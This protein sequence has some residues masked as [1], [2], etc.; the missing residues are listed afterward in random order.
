MTHITLTTPTLPDQSDLINKARDSALSVLQAQNVHR[1]SSPRGKNHYRHVTSNQAPSTIGLAILL[2][3]QDSKWNPTAAELRDAMAR[4]R[5]ILT[6]PEVLATHE[7]INPPDVFMALFDG[8]ITGDVFAVENRRE[9]LR[10]YTPEKLATLTPEGLTAML[11]VDLSGSEPEPVAIEAPKPLCWQCE[12]SSGRLVPMVP[13]TDPTNPIERLEAGQTYAAC[14]HAAAG[15]MAF[16]PTSQAIPITTLDRLDEQWPRPT[17][18]PIV[19]LNEARN[20]YED[21]TGK[22]APF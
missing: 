9:A 11:R 12:H 10:A 13:K 7:A 8:H 20:R 3:D 5:T 17:F 19:D 14:T 16:N 15:A 4:A 22:D 18:C 1:S 21:L 6:A 2:C